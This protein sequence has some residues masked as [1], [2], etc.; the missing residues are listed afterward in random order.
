MCAS[1]PGLYTDA[2]AAHPDGFAGAAE[3]ERFSVMGSQ[4]DLAGI[5]VRVDVGTS[6]GFYAATR[7]YVEGFPPGADVTSTFGEGGHSLDYSTRVMP[8][9]LA[10]LGERVGSTT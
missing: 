7:A 2:T 8:A 6:D 4:G 10:F 5:P 9:E 3:Y 1:S